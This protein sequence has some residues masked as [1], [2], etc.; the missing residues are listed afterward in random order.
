[1]EKPIVYVLVGCPA[2]GK[3]TFAK[4]FGNDTIIISSDAI[5]EELYGDEATQGNGNEVFGLY[6]D[7]AIAA[8]KDGYNVILDATNVTRKARKNIFST[9]GKN[10][11]DCKFVAICFEK[12]LDILLKQNAERERKVPKEVIERMY[13]NY[14]RPVDQEGFDKIVLI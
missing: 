3:S 6:Y 12:E 14:V 10:N 11:I 2:C 1:M 4:S 9:L 5:R 13:N 8:I 7:R